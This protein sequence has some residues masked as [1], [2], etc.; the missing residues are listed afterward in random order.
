MECLLVKM[1]RRRTFY[2]K[3]LQGY[4]KPFAK[5]RSLPQE[6]PWSMMLLALMLRPGMLLLRHL[7][8]VPRCLADDLLVLARGQAT[9]SD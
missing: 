6:D 8:V 4:G 5:E 7:E 1:A 9:T 2:I 3:M